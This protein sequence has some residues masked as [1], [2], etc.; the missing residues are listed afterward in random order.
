MN[1]V[2]ILF[3]AQT[4]PTATVDGVPAEELE[5]QLENPKLDLKL[6]LTTQEKTLGSHREFIL[7]ASTI[8]EIL[9]KW[10][11]YSRCA[12]VCTQYIHNI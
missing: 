7:K 6:A 5:K 1:V 4:S 12:V 3:R 9:E 10:P 2:I 8:N 11:I